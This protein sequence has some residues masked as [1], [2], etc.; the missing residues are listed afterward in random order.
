[1]DELKSASDFLLSVSRTI[2]ALRFYPKNHPTLK[3]ALQENYAYFLKSLNENGGFSLNIHRDSFEVNGLNPDEKSQFS[4]LSEEFFLRGVKK[5]TVKDFVN[6]DEFIRFFNPLL[7]EPKEVIERGGFSQ[8]MGKTRG[9]TLEEMDFE[10]KTRILEEDGEV[11]QL[12]RGSALEVMESISISTTEFDEFNPQDELLTSEEAKVKSLLKELKKTEDVNTAKALL[13]EILTR[14]RNIIS[15]SEFRILPYVLK[16]FYEIFIDQNKSAEIRRF[17]AEVARALVD[18]KSA[19]FFIKKITE[20]ELTKVD[21]L[22][23]VFI[24]LGETIIK[25]LLESLFSEETPKGRRIIS[26]IIT[27]FGRK[28]IPHILSYL[29]RKEWFI[30]RNSLFLL[31]E[32]GERKGISIISPFLVH[33]DERIQ[34]EAI[35]ALSK[36]PHKDTLSILLKAL[37]DVK[38]KIKPLVIRAIGELRD[39]TTELL[40]VNYT[41]APQDEI[42][43]EALLALAKMKSGY[44]L[45]IA[46]DWLNKKGTSK[47]LID[48]AFHAIELLGS[49]QAVDAIESYLF[50][51]ERHKMEMAVDV[52]SK[53]AEKW[54]I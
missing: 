26:R 53:I 46:K 40:M 37:D 31:G 44:A 6:M 30:V 39:T 24:M 5:I 36:I 3:K 45:S 2:S 43:K 11:N 28:A 20:L 19:L 47:E 41:E 17:T 16:S 33:H 7:L 54:G 27:K 42:R 18:E 23:D 1:M 15:T 52:L 9:I 8:I 13:K 48:T 38:P 25:Y 49:P 35:I 34:K 50:D 21:E 12:E 4:K 14:M 10:T 51:V 22:S 29:H 32:I